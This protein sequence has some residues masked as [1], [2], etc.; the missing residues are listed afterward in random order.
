MSKKDEFNVIVCGVGGQGSVRLSHII[1][2]A[3]VNAGLNARVGEKFGAAQRGGAVASHV[4]IGK[5]VHGPMVEVDGADLI[6][7]LEPLE[8]LRV[9]T[10]YIAP[11]GIIIMEKRQ[12]PSAD[13]N[14]GLA[15]YPPLDEIINGLKKLAKEVYV[16]NGTEL[17]LKAGNPKTLNIVLLGAA[18]ALDI[19]PFDIDTLKETVKTHVPPKTIEVNMKAFDLGFQT[20]K[21]MLSK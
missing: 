5:E 12:I 10:K 18:A 2:A 3:A 19:F 16:L 13:I 20:M 4:R 6:I 9:G 14:F 21:D 8:T 11:N 1:A 7:G 17:A 15:K